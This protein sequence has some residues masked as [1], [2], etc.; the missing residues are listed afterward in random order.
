VRHDDINP[1]PDHKP[2]WSRSQRQWLQVEKAAANDLTAVMDME[3]LKAEIAQWR[4][5]LHFIDFETATPAIPMSKGEHP[6]Q[7][8]AFQF[9]HHVLHADGTVE[10]KDQFINDEIGINPNLKFIRA[11]MHSLSGDEGTVF[12]YH[13]HENTYL[14]M[15][16]QQLFH[17][18]ESIKDKD[19][20]LRFIESIAI[21]GKNSPHKWQS[22]ERAMVDLCRLVER[23]TFDPLTKGFTSIK[24]VFPAIL[25]RSAYLKNK[26]SKPVYGA[27]NGLRSLNFINMQ[28][29]QMEQGVVTDP[30]QLLPPVFTDIDMK[31]IDL[32]FTDDE[33]KGG[34][35][36]T[37][38][39]MR[40][41]FSEMSSQERKAIRESLLRYCELDTLA[42]VMIVEAW[43]YD[44]ANPNH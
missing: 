29:V 20:I 23:Y 38:A 17:S 2:G 31:D 44:L 37:I 6:Y 11:L 41:Q 26:Y 39:Y 16:Y 25:Q 33:I 10:H 40:M 18:T 7:G 9:S 3:G 12:R 34:G 15:I 43:L 5:P 24:K 30:Y 32:L 28:W 13:T 4:Y 21:P 14:N 22:G 36:A 42:M 35:P 19:S 8:I 27:T 1:Q